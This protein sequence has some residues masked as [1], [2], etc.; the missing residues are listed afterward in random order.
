MV[1]SL[2]IIMDVSKNL[3]FPWRLDMSLHN[4]DKI[5]LSPSIKM[6]LNLA[7]TTTLK[8]LRITIASAANMD[9]APKLNAL[10]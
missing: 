2:R 3:D 7:S 6:L 1:T 4:L 5:L 10:A 9:G 8:P